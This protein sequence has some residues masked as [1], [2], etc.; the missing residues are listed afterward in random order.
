MFRLPLQLFW[1]MKQVSIALFLARIAQLLVLILIVFAFAPVA[2]FSIESLPLAVF[3]AVLGSVVVSALT[4]TV[5][6]YFVGKKYLKIKFV[7]FM[8]FWKTFVQ[9]KRKYGLSQFL[10][11]LY[12]P[13]ILIILS[14]L[15]PTVQNFGYVGQWG[16]ALS[17]IGMLLIVPSSLGDSMLHKVAAYEVDYQRRSF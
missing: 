8:S 17:L 4:E 9:E 5:Y 6:V 2:T 16:L 10:S 7:P 11:G 12:I 3:L 13:L 14:V 15:Y 1:N